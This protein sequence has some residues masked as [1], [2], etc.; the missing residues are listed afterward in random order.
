M[1]KKH[2]TKVS[3]LKMKISRSGDL[4][5][6]TSKGASL[7]TTK[8]HWRPTR[9]GILGKTNKAIP[10]KLGEIQEGRKTRQHVTNNLTA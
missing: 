9:A 6:L 7:S 4:R 8:N 10:M 3:N 2:T 1:Y 5:K